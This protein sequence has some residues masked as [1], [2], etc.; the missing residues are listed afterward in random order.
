MKRNLFKK[1]YFF[2][3]LLHL[4]NM[5]TKDEIHLRDPILQYNIQI[6]KAKRK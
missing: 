5:C 4:I 2:V 1:I 6:K 3:I